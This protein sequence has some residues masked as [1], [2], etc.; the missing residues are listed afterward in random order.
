MVL[1]NP[2]DYLADGEV[3]MLGGYRHW[4]ASGSHV[5]NPVRHQ[6][7]PSAPCAA[8]SDGKP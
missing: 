3:Y 7:V 8:V 6:S 1:L 5:V 4:A 2:L